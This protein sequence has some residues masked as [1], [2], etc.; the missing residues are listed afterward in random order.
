VRPNFT[1]ALLA[2]GALAAP[3]LAQRHP[4]QFGQIT[5]VAI[6]GTFDRF[7]EYSVE[8]LLPANTMAK[9]ALVMS[10]GRNRIG[11]SGPVVRSNSLGEFYGNVQVP[12]AMKLQALGLYSLDGK[13]LWFGQAPFR[14]ESAP[15]A[16]TVLRSADRRAAGQEPSFSDRANRDLCAAKQM[17]R[18]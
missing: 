12:K 15:H 9:L 17:R 14:G 13:L 2:L 1:V 4:A 7:N 6:E 3:A 11:A 10:D 16:L 5:S 18:R 8:G